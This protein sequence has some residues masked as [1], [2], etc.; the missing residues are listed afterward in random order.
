M[1]HLEDTR[2]PCENCGELVQRRFTVECDDCGG[3]MNVCVDCVN[4]DT[5]HHLEVTCVTND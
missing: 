3:N 4:A 1:T 5:T 2:R